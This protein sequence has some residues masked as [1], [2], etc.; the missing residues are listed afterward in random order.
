[1]GAKKV[2]NLDSTDK[3]IVKVI[4]LVPG[5]VQPIHTI[6]KKDLDPQTFWSEYV[7]KHRPVVIKGGANDWPA[8]KNWQ[9]PGYLESITPPTLQTTFAR[10]FNPEPADRF[11]KTMTKK[12]LVE[13]IREMRLLS[14]ADT[15][16]IPAEAVPKEWLNDFGSY[17]FF[18]K[19]NDKPPRDYPNKRLFIYKNASTEWHYHEFDETLTTQIL[20]SKRVSM[21]RLDANNWDDYNSIIIHNQHHTSWGQQLFNGIPPITKFEGIIDP[22]DV[23]YIPP[24]WWHGIDPVDTELG[25]TFAHCFA[26]PWS[27]LAN[28]D[29]PVFSRDAKLQLPRL[30]AYFKIQAYYII[31]S[32][33][34]FIKNEKW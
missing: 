5:G 21:F 27:R 23:I 2:V 30:K 10:S 3:G 33:M 7:C 20:G 13:C 17:S 31:S 19:K 16:S 25:I 29:E 8:V 18:D 22:G 26:S 1:M 4:D 32:F 11:F 9:K 34:R 6:N 14:E 24:F 12:S 28:R 15:Y